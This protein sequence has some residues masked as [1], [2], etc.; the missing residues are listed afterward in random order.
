MCSFNS[1]TIHYKTRQDK[2]N[3][4][5]SNQTKGCVMTCHVYL[6]ITEVKYYIQLS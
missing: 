2:T 6:I 4:I 1:I 3:Q 5:K